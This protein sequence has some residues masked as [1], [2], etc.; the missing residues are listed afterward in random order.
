MCICSEKRRP[1]PLGEFSQWRYHRRGNFT[2]ACGT[3]P[4]KINK[5]VGLGRQ[6]ANAATWPQAKIQQRQ[7]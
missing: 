1:E 3:M 2:G 4:Q 6:Q 7:S 5:I